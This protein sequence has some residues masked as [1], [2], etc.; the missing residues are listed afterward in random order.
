MN[1]G[2]LMSCCV[3][4]NILLAVSLI[5]LNQN[6]RFGV[7]DAENPEFCSLPRFLFGQSMGGAVALKVHLKQ[8][9]AWNGAILVAPMCKVY[10]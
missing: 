3:V 7:L 4:H 2:F 9:N 6:G 5:V 1:A 8:P 10:V